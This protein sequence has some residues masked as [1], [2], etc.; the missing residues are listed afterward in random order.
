M[1]T[2]FMIKLKW[3][4]FSVPFGVLTDLTSVFFYTVSYQT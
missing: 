4:G 2:V 3:N 1:V